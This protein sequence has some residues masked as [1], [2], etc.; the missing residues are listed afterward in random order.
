MLLLFWGAGTASDAVVAPP[1]VHFY[2]GGGTGFFKRKKRHEE[3]DEL[4]DVQAAY[5]EAPGSSAVA[6]VIAPFVDL[7]RPQDLPLLLA[8]DWAALV[9]AGKLAALRQAIDSAKAAEL[10]RMAEQ[11]DEDAFLLLV[12]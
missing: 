4:A 3:E 1:A 11:D 12:M 2:E 8:V 9:R 5:E 6:A 7:E 10:A